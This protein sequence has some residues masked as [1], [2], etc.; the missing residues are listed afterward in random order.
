MLIFLKFSSVV[1]K[2]LVVFQISFVMTLTKNTKH[3]IT[4]PVCMQTADS[5]LYTP[6]CVFCIT[7]LNRAWKFIMIAFFV[8]SL[9]DLVDFAV[10][11]QFYK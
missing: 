1:I 2:E 4:H 3:S 8:E 7:R 6:S 10:C 5:Y 11:Q 9:G